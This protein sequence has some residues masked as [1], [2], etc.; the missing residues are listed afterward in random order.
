MALIAATISLAAGG[1]TVGP[2]GPAGPTTPSGRAAGNGTAGTGTAGNGTAG[3]GTAGNGPAAG[4][5]PSAST[6]PTVDPDAARRVAVLDLV[7]RRTAALTA[8]DK[9]TWLATVADP[10]S[11]FG[12]RQGAVFDR[13]LKLP[14]NGFGGQ[15][16]D[17]AGPLTPARAAVLGG[18]AW[19]ATVHQSYELVGFDRAPRGYDASFTV[20]RTAAGWRFAD[21][22]DGSSQP[23]PWDLP[24]LTVVSSP[25]TL[26]MGD[27][28]AE[29]LRQYLALGDAAHARIAG[30]WGSALPA[31]IVAP[32]RVEELTAQLHRGTTT[33]LDQVAAVTDGP[34]VADQPAGSDRVYLNPQAFSRLTTEGRRVVVTHELTHVTVRGTTTR[35]APLWLSE[36]F[37]DYVGFRGLRLPPRSVAADLLKKVR[38]GS[39]PTGLPGAIDFDPSRGVIAPTYSA[40]WLAVTRMAA[41]HGQDAAVRFY[42]AVAA[43][44]VGDPALS[45]DPDAL[46]ARAFGSVLGT[47]ESA[48]TADW[49]AYLKTLAR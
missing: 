5:G 46:T 45:H 48:F 9:G 25:T 34:I 28:P 32:A 42:R 7:A 20:V 22:T 21:D 15:G 27:L 47:T 4:N 39:G 11:P 19:V 44:S 49:L 26:V 8:R 23:Q 6:S 31:V 10:G 3:N 16:V 18:D 17:V 14:I 1:C 24:S 30:V 2:G 12:R 29:R 35:A 13:M 33:G 37:A 40:A 38:A 36:G 41:M 43:D